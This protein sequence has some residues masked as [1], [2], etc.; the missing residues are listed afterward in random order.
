MS[1]IR[2]GG[3]ASGIDTESIIKQMM[4]IERTKVDRVSQQKQVSLWKQEQFRSIN[5]KLANFVIDAKLSFGLATT[6]ASGS[7]L[8]TNRNAMTWVKKAVSTNES[9]VS[10][11]ASAGATNGSYNVKVNSLASNWSAASSAALGS[12]EDKTSLASQFSLDAA[13]NINFTIE[14]NNGS[15]TFDKSAGDTSISEMV[16]EINAADLGVTAIYDAGADRFFLQT[17]NTGAE[18]TIMITDN[19]T[20]AFIA[21]GE[22][23]LKLQHEVSG[24]YEAVGNAKEYGGKDANIDFGAATGITFSSNDFTLNNINFSLKDTTAT[25]FQVNVSA[26]ID[27][28]FDKI[29]EFVDNYNKIVDEIDSLTSQKRDSS[30]MPLTET[31]KEAMSDKEVELWEERAKAG[32]L[33]KDATLLRIGSSSRTG[34]YQSVDGVAGNFYHLTQLGITT[35][36]YSGSSAGGRLQIDEQKLKTALQQDIDGV[37]EVLFKEADSSLGGNEDNLTAEQIKDKRAQSGLVNR[38]FDNLTSGMKEI[39]YQ[40]GPG[41]DAGLMRKVNPYMLL[42]FATKQSSISYIDKGI[43]DYNDRIANLERV[44]SSKE[45]SYWRKYTAMEK[46]LSSMESQ[47]TS[48]TQQ[49]GM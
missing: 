41:D 33:S 31:Q 17:S 39:V 36:A 21:G 40:A 6:T 4:D 32:L 19:S 35:E 43:L 12:A 8:G 28:A 47:M 22:S 26:D 15:F 1:A 2:F 16:K 44:L 48:L 20:K 27:S 45:E 25:S 13:D 37:M 3:I 5:S 9:A 14:T 11:S 29:K 46:A 34:F 38:L 10:V 18:N 30:Y 49:L 7:L 23:T 42:S 24:V